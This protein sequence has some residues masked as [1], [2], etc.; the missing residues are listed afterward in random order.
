MLARPAPQLCPDQ[1][2]PARNL[3]SH[4]TNTRRAG[5]VKDAQL[6]LQLHRQPVSQLHGNKA[7]HTVRVHRFRD[8]HVPD[9]HGNDLGHALEENLLRYPSRPVRRCAARELCDELRDYAAVREPYCRL[10]S[11]VADVAE[12]GKRCLRGD[13]EHADVGVFLVCCA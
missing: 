7:V 2:R 5:E 4:I 1:H 10:G 13:P 3:P 12:V 6:A 9:G 11:A 8:V